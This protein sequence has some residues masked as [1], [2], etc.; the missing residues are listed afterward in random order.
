MKTGTNEKWL[1]AGIVA[2]ILVVHSMDAP[3]QETG[4][5][6]ECTPESEWRFQ[7]WG[8]EKKQRAIREETRT[9]IVRQCIDGELTEFPAMTDSDENIA[10]R[11]LGLR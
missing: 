11:I 3:A 5:R 4:W 9:V 7:V 8:S 2:L 10:L 6:L 1:L